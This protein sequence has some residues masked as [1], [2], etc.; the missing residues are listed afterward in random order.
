MKDLIA[1]QTGAETLDDRST[2]DFLFADVVPPAAVLVFKLFRRETAALFC[3]QSE[4]CRN[5]S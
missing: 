5:V 4:S 3:I 1:R 2:A